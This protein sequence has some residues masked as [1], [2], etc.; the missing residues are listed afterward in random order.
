LII[1]QFTSIIDLDVY[2]F[3]LVYK[4]VFEDKSIDI[5]KKGELLN[6]LKGVIESL[7]RND[8]HKKSPGNLKYLKERI[9]QSIEVYNKYETQQPQ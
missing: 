7:K 1:L 6:E 5:S 4:I 2:L 9:K 8:S 3:G